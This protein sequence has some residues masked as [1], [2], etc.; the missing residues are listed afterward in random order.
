M[1]RLRSLASSPATL[2]GL[3]STMAHR[4]NY[5]SRSY[6]GCSVGTWVAILSGSF[7]CGPYW[8]SFFCDSQLIIKGNIPELNYRYAVCTALT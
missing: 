3:A 7:V 5:W 1:I 6:L 4:S 8:A 2:M